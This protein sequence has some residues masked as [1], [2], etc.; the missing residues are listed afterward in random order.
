M[1]TINCLDKKVIE[2][3]HIVL[4][5]S[6]LKDLVNLLENNKEESLVYEFNEPIRHVEEIRVEE[7]PVKPNR[8]TVDL[9]LRL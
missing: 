3:D 2:F 6:Q 8:V 1:K 4:T 9:I 5:L 7:H